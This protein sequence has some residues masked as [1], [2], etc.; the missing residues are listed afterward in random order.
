MPAE[1]GDADAAELAL[2]AGVELRIGYRTGLFAPA[3]AAR[4]AEHLCR[5][6][7]QLHQPVRTVRLADEQD[8]AL[9]VGRFNDT[10]WPYPADVPVHRL[11]EEQVRRAPDALAVSWRDQG[12]SYAQLD[13]QAE[14]LAGA[15]RAAGV[16]PGEP[17][18]L[19]IGRTP[20]LVAGVLAILKTGAAYLPI[21]PDYP[22]GRVEFLL[23]DA[24]AR[25]LVTDSPLEAA[26]GG[27]V[28]DPA[29]LVP[30][31]PVGSEQVEH[32]PVVPDL[33]TDRAA[34]LPV[35]HLRHHRPSQGRPGHPSQHRAAGARR[36]V[37]RPRAAYPSA[38][39]R[40][41]LVRRQH[42]RAVGHPAQRWQL[43]LVDNDVVFSAPALRAELTAERSH[44]PVADRAAVQPDRRAG[45]GHLPPAA[46]A[47]HRRRRA[48]PAA[49][50]EGAGG[51][52]RS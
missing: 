21:D 19:R 17:V 34:G 3:T 33:P 44:H 1:S 29:A 6:L 45:P 23:A 7:A 4:L 52:A 11:F 30:C 13:G 41:D 16:R 39:D 14:T 9:I 51:A 26:F 32:E 50:R 46:R 28:L 40:V 12:L 42:L 22:P 24:R 5:V 43:H 31:G 48:V 25:V 35:L 47:V 15:L 8:R 2:H 37:L 20:D 36:R 38:D 18:A 27:T 10:A 49:R